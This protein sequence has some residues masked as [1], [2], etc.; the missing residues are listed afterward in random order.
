MALKGSVVCKACGWSGYPKTVTE[1]STAIELVLWLFLLVPGLVYSIW[2]LTTRHQ[3]CPTCGGKILVPASSPGGRAALQEKNDQT[4]ERPCPQCGEQIKRIARV[5][6]HCRSAVDPVFVDDPE[7]NRQIV[8]V[9]QLAGKG[10]AVEA[11][12]AELQRR[13]IACLAPGQSWNSDLIRQIMKDFALKQ[14]N[15][16]SINGQ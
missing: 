6:K 5:C 12:V 11:I 15:P 7:V 10:M 9:D 4:A 14:H 1:G 16:Y 3:A 2:R 8:L 13:Q